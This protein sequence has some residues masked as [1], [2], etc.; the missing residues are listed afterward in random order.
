MTCP[1]K[2]P[3]LRQA[4]L[5]VWG[6]VPWDTM[7]SSERVDRLDHLLARVRL[8]GGQESSHLHRSDEDYEFNDEIP[9][10]L[11]QT[12]EKWVGDEQFEDRISLEGTLTDQRRLLLDH[13]KLIGHLLVQHGYRRSWKLRFSSHDSRCS[14]HAERIAIRQ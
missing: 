1:P 13:E 9:E 12:I 4:V 7:Q 8:E 14:W 2:T 10:P 11:R 5:W 3:V 6:V